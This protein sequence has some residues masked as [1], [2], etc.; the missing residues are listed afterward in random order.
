MN[1]VDINTLQLITA[2][3]YFPTPDEAKAMAHELIT[4][5]LGTI[6]ARRNSR[7]PLNE[8]LDHFSGCI[9]AAMEQQAEAL[10]REITH[11][12]LCPAREGTSG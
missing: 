7:R 11:V 6:T 1:E 10:E 5:R 9:V 12:N 4:R 3:C 2:G 8:K